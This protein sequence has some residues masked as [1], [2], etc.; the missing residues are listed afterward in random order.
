MTAIFSAFTTT[1]K[2]PVSTCGVYALTTFASIQPGRKDELQ[3][4]LDAY[5]EFVGPQ[6]PPDGPYPFRA[7]RRNC[8]LVADKRP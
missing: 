3:A 6:Q 2:S 4:Y 5:V 8:V 1:T 7:T